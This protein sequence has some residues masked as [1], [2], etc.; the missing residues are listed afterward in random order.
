MPINNSPYFINVYDPQS[1]EII[2]KPDHF[3]VGTENLIE[4]NLFEKSQAFLIQL[5]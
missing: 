3:K 5:V 4:G 2:R 1:A